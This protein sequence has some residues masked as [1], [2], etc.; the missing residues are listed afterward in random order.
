MNTD[1]DLLIRL[2]KLFPVKE[3]KDN[4]ETNASGEELQNS[5]VETIVPGSIRDFAY[6]NIN[7]T[8]QHVYIYE[9]QIPYDIGSFNPDV[10]PYPII[11]RTIVAGQLQ[12]IISPI[13]EFQVALNNP[14]EEV[15]LNF[16]QPFII[17]ISNRHI[18]FQ[19]TI[20][21]KNMT[22]YFGEE[23]KVLKVDKLND[24]RIII[25][26]ITS[27]FN[28]STP[29]R[30]DLNRGV[31]HLWQI[32]TIDSKYIKYKRNRSTDTVMMDENYT[33]KEQYADDYRRIVDNP[34]G[35]TIFRYL[36]EDDIMPK[37]FTIDPTMGEI[38]VPLFPLTQTQIPNVITQILSNN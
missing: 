19:A 24:E 29:I 14:L 17:T 12:L 33:L 11:T 35:K 10:F 3:L 25:G 27:Y 5:I 34:I 9:F 32:D 21:E 36:P 38:S 26:N 22:S 13:V 31:K 2:L 4:F 7:A 8:K 28:R 15:V 30:C 37:H 6:S 23:R 18:I 1:I 16:H 20:M